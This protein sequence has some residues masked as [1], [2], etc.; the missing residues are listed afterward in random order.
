MAEIVRMTS[1]KH[2]LQVGVPL[3][4]FSHA[5]AFARGQ[6]SGSDA[7]S[8]GRVAPLPVSSDFQAPPVPRII[9]ITP[10]PPPLQASWTSQSSVNMQ[11]M[12][13]PHVY[14]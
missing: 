2:P 14:L 7:S 5:T 12:V 1:Q 11:T 4:P 13:D 8:P 10:S 3:F 9:P 6:A